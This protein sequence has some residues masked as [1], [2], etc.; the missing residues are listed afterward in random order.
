MKCETRHKSLSHPNNT[1]CAQLVLRVRRYQ[2]DPLYAPTTRS[3]L[4]V[5]IDAVYL[6]RKLCHTI[7]YCRPA[8]AI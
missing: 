4:F 1:P 2:S 3:Q 5:T 8:N 7:C 6:L